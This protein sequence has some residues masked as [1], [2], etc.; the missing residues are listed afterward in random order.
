MKTN[1]GHT[2]KRTPGKYS[3]LSVGTQVKKIGTTPQKN[4]NISKVDQM[5]GHNINPNK[6]KRIEI[7]GRIFSNHNENKENCKIHKY[8]KIKYILKQPVG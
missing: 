3:R 6:Y 1:L 7:I 8:V 4:G 2:K 5:P